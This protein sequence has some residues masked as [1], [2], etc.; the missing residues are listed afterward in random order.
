MNIDY[1]HGR[2]RLIF[3]DAM[4]ARI[5]PLTSHGGEVERIILDVHHLTSREAERFI[6]NVVNITRGG[7]VIEVIH[8]YRHGT[9]IKNMLKHRF[10]NPNIKQITADR[11]NLGITYLQPG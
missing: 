2:F 10:L 11:W 3:T 4:I 1:I 5:K 6:N 7:C 8:G 9:R